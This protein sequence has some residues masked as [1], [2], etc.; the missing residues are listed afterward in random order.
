M[1]IRVAEQILTMPWEEAESFICNNF[2]IGT[3]SMG[4]TH[5]CLEFFVKEYE[6]NVKYY[7]TVRTGVTS[8]AFPNWEP[9]PE[10]NCSIYRGNECV[11]KFSQEL[12]NDGETLEESLLHGV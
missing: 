9:A 5:R 6:E 4:V 3:H 2:E 8:Q 10:L 7:Y 1:D 12:C 11:L